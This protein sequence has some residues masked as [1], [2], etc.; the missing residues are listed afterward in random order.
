MWGVVV[1]MFLL[2]IIYIFTL[3][4]EKKVTPEEVKWLAQSCTIIEYKLEKQ[5]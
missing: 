1:S 4:I 5:F 3:E 2:E